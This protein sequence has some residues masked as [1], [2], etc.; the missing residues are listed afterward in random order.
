M[1]LCIE[2]EK[3]SFLLFLQGCIYLVKCF[4]VRT[5]F[6]KKENFANYA[7]NWFLCNSSSYG[8]YDERRISST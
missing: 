6:Y 1:I 2:H 7:K 3:T 5:N 8:F 4:F